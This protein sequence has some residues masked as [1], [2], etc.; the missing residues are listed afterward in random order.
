MTS[1]EIRAYD[2]VNQP[3]EAVRDALTNDAAAIFQ[4]AT[5]LAEG[6]SGELVAALS[7]NV[8]GLELS[9]D[10]QLSVGETREEQR[11]G[12]RLS[13][14]LHVPLSWQAAQSPGLFPIMRGECLVYPLSSSETQIELQGHYQPP[15]GALGGALDA[16]AGHRVAEAS[17]H[18]FVRAVVERLRHELAKG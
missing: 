7:V 8:R 6:R 4:R 2:Y 15:F 9:T 16:V 11:S 18:R 17:I 3:Y 13:R 10:V 5:K 14:T 12:S 1:R